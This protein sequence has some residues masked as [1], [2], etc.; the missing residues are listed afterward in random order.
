MNRGEVWWM[1]H[2]EAGRHPACILTRQAARSRSY[3]RCSWRRR[4]PEH[5]SS[6]TSPPKCGWGPR[7]EEGVNVSRSIMS[8]TYTSPANHALLVNITCVWSCG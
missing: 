2:P 3:K 1:E 4:A 7:T 5:P 6:R 8:I